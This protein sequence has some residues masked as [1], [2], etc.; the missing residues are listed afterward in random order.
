MNACF[1]Y[2]DT[3]SLFFFKSVQKRTDL[4]KYNYYR[5]MSL[6]SRNTEN[7]TRNTRKLDWKNKNYTEK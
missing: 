5:T 4:S 6:K 1:I 2:T 3:P 7:T